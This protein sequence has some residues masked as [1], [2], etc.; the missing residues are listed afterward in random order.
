MNLGAP[1]DQRL[2]SLQYFTKVLG[3]EAPA[4][5]AQSKS[6]TRMQSELL[7][8][9][10]GAAPTLVIGSAY[11]AL[12]DGERAFVAAHQLG[13]LRQEHWLSLLHND[14]DVTQSILNWAMARAHGDMRPATGPLAPQL[15]MIAF[16]NPTLLEQLQLIAK[17]LQQSGSPLDARRWHQ[18]QTETCDRIALVL[19][20]DLTAAARS[21]AKDQCGA[22]VARVT[23]LL[24]FSVSQPY[25]EIRDVMA[26][27][28]P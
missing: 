15:D 7:V 28:A 19:C 6:A 11:L 1:V 8:N 13:R 27:K 20:G 26:L 18:G 17:R 22:T 12:D 4:L 3:L 2:S 24:K 25:F 9:K 16:D 10:G 21:I 14:P 23:E 5:Y